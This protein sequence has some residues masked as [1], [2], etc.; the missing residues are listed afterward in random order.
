[1]NQPL[2]SIAIATYGQAHCV[3]KAISSALAQDYTPLEVV[4]CDDASP[5]A[6]P[7]VVSAFAGETLLRYVRRERNL[8]RAGNYRRALRDCAGEWMLMLDGDDWLIDAGYVGRVMRELSKHHGVVLACAGTR[9]LWPDG[10]C[11]DVPATRQAWEVKPGCDYFLE[12]GAWLGVSHQSA[13]YPRQLAIDLDFYRSN[14]ISSDWE[15]LRRLVLRGSILLHGQTVCVWKRHAAGA[16]ASSD[17]LARIDDLQSIQLPYEDARGL[18][19]DT[20]RL[21]TWRRDTVAAYCVDQMRAALLAGQKADA[22]A[23]FEHLRQHD[24]MAYAVCRRRIMT[25]LSMLWLLGVNGLGATRLA[26]W[27]AETWRKLK[28]RP[29]AQKER[30]S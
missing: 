8:G 19:V 25:S 30:V 13:L 24:P 18:G 11:Q 21:E 26:A 28:S 2:V 17:V 6:T 4:V 12:W 3:R 22:L 7:A 10:R 20:A 29:F 5:D 27:P 16:S 14:I 23:L 9:M 1:M 15:S